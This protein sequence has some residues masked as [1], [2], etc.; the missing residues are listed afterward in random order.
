VITTPTPMGSIRY[1]PR[2]LKAEIRRLRQAGDT[3]IQAPWPVNDRKPGDPGV[4]GTGT[5]SIPVWA[6]YSPEQLLE[7]ARVILEGM[8]EAY[9]WIV[10]RYF[11]RLKPAMRTAVTLPA[12]VEGVLVPRCINNYTGPDGVPILQW[13]LEPLDRGSKSKVALRLASSPVDATKPA[14]TSLTRCSYS[15]RT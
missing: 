13:Y 4:K 15:G 7:R 9:Q 12:R 3:E 14:K 11:A 1:Y 10:E 2:Y 8:L 6:L 5:G